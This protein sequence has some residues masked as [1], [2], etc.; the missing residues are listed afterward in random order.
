MMPEHSNHEPDGRTFRS[1]INIWF[2]PE[3]PVHLEIKTSTPNSTRTD[4]MKTPLPSQKNKPLIPF[5]FQI[6]A[7]LD[8][9]PAVK[10]T[11]SGPAL[12]RDFTLD[13]EAFQRALNQRIEETRRRETTVYA[14]NSRIAGM[15]PARAAAPRLNRNAPARKSRPDAC[16]GL[17][18]MEFRLKAPEAKSVKLAADFTEWEK[19]PLDMIPAADGNWFTIVPLMPGYYSYR[20]IVDGKWCDDP[21][22]VERLQDSPGHADAIVNVK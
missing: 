2:A 6:A 11:L 4:S 21:N 3:S 13:S 17:R 19:F 9:A 14:R 20:F 12:F 5:L 8:T 1:A 16:A 10:T 15:A 18:R 22:P 7:S